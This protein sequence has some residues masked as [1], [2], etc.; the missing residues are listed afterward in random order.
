MKLKNILLSLRFF[1]VA[2]SEASGQAS[3]VPMS[4]GSISRDIYGRYNERGDF[5]A[6]TTVPV[7]EGSSSPASSL[8]IPHFADSGGFTT[9]FVVFSTDG[10]VPSS[11]FLTVFG[12]SGKNPQFG[13]EG[14]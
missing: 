3:L 1:A 9:R 7:S 14:P 2:M 4:P 6:S 5:L 11:G 13:A 8:F 12:D 10:T